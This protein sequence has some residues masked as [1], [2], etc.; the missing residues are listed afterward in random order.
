MKVQ[1]H[2]KGTQFLNHVWTLDM[3]QNNFNIFKPCKFR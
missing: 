2:K 3:Q 1:H